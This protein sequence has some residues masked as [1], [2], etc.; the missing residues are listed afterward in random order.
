MISKIFPPEYFFDESEDFFDEG[1]EGELINWHPCFE[2]DNVV[3][4]N[5]DNNDDDEDDD[6]GGG[7]DGHDVNDGASDLDVRAAAS[8]GMLFLGRRRLPMHHYE[9][10][11]TFPYTGNEGA[12]RL[13][14]YHAAVLIACDESLVTSL[15]LPD[16]WYVEQSLMVHVGHCL[17]KYEQKK[18]P[19]YAPTEHG[20]L[21]ADA[22]AAT[23]AHIGPIRE[24]DGH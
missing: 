15:R 18:G 24:E 22:A 10:G 17:D 14:A 20:A 13:A 1:F 23:S 12:T 4:A 6:G 16:N 21:A 19:L 2:G 3:V 11:D 8:G 5:T 9:L 7:A